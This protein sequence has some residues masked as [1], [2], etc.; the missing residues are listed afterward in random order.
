MVDQKKVKALLRVL[1]E[2][3]INDIQKRRPYIPTLG[4]DYSREDVVKWLQKRKD[5]VKRLATAADV[6]SK[7]EELVFTG[8]TDKAA[9]EF[10]RKT[11]G[12]EVLTEG[13]VTASDEA[14]FEKVALL[15]VSRL[16]MK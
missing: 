6:T 13:D 11:Q 15:S 14:L 4:R 9:K 2:K 12:K 16:V 3:D 7:V 5:F 8:V 10:L 1:S